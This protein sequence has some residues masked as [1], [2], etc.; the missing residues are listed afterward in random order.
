MMGNNEMNPIP[1]AAVAPTSPVVA[2]DDLHKGYAC[3]LY[4][5]GGV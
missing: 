5:S 1:A 3:L 4:T 2:I